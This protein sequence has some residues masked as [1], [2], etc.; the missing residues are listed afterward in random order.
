MTNYE[1][2]KEWL[3]A[4]G[5]EPSPEN[6]SVQIGCQLE[7]FC[8]L[9]SCLR[10]DSDGYAKLL[11]RTRV[12]LEWFAK[13][14][15]RREQSLYVPTHLRGDALDA[16]CDIEVTGNGVAFL[17]GFD[18]DAADQAV[19]DSND[20]KLED[21]KAVILEGGKIGKGKDYKAP[22]LRDFV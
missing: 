4:C 11:E 9:L 22:N 17:A 16:L 8:E 20:S 1:R 3:I 15:K 12:D 14:L 2:T 13:K 18:K 5:K 6:L 19:M 21:G 7:E 10:T